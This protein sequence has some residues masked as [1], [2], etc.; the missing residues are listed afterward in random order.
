MKFR[1]T[2]LAAL[3]TLALAGITAQADEL[4]TGYYDGTWI[5]RQVSCGGQP[6]N[7]GT[8]SLFTAPNSIAVVIDGDTGAFVD[9]ING[10]TKTIPLRFEYP[11]DDQITAYFNGPVT[12]YPAGC[13]PMC[14]LD[15][16]VSVAYEA[17]RSNNLLRWESQGSVDANC[18]ANGQQDPINYLMTRG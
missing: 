7:A 18:S 9:R 8:R 14:G 11:T 16:P 5:V 10:C 15:I 2:T 17:Y 12:C 1:A 6:A 13:D 4:A 3:A